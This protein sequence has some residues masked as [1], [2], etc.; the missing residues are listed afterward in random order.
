[1]MAVIVGTVVIIVV[2][3]SSS[4]CSC[5]APSNC[6][7]P[8]ALLIFF[9]VLRSVIVNKLGGTGN[10]TLLEKATSVVKRVHGRI[11]GIALVS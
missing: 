6:L 2:L 9:I 10:A 5:V 8:I 4:S 1:M 11:F 3:G 7:F